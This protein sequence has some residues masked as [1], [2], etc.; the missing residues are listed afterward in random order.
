MTAYITVTQVMTL[1]GFSLVLIGLW[2]ILTKRN[3]IRI[4]IA[5]SI[6]DTGVHLIMVGLGYV[7]GGTAPIFDSDLAVSN[8]LGKVV[9]PIPSA[10][11]LT[12]IVIGIAVTALMLS[13]AVR[14]H[15]T[16]KTL[17]IDQIKEMKW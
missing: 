2:G 13:Y 6:L 8:A 17:S 16:Y 3:I 11:V 1:L 9:D 10:L 15:N 14:L 5:F 4:I 12:A 7:E